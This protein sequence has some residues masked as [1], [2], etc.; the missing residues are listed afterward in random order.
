MHTINFKKIVANTLYEL[1]IALTISAVLVNM[2]WVFYGFYRKK[3]RW[4]YH[5]IQ[6]LSQLSVL[7]GRLRDDIHMAGLVG[8]TYLTRNFPIYNSSNELFTIENKIIGQDLNQLTVRHASA[9]HVPLLQPAEK[10]SRSLWLGDQFSIKQ[11]DLLIIS[12]CLTADMVKVLS[13]NYYHDMQ[14]IILEQPLLNTYNIPAEVARFEIHHYYLKQNSTN[15]GDTLYL[16]INNQPAFALMDDIK[17]LHIAYLLFQ[18]GQL[19]IQAASAIKQWSMV[20]GVKIH[21]IQD[22]NLNNEWLEYIPINQG[23]YDA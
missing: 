23:V 8:C 19:T 13:V 11:G 10:A 1:L 15:H 14:K 4:Q 2:V 7:A 17:K 9:S 5:T 3:I 21:L 20:Q 12:N 18:H 22:R 16:K 6:N